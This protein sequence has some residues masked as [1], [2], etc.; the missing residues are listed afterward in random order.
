MKKLKV[1]C[2]EDE[3]HELNFL[4]NSQLLAFFRFIGIKSIL[5][6]T[7]LQGP[8]YRPIVFSRKNITA[9]IGKVRCNKKILHFLTF[10]SIALFEQKI[11]KSM[12]FLKM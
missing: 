1:L 2:I 10:N 5:F 11:S 8:Y 4:F 9:L 6:S 7:M 3:L 12:H